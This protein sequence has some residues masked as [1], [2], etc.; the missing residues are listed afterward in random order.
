M[1]ET[2]LEKP[3]IE[4]PTEKVIAHSDEIREVECMAKEGNPLPTFSWE[5]KEENAETSWIPWNSEV[6]TYLMNSGIFRTQSDI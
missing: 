6:R 2:Y 3:V 1:L 4:I 5:Y